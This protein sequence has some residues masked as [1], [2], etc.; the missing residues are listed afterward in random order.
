MPEQFDRLSDYVLRAGKFAD[1]SA[2]REQGMR[3]VRR[4]KAGQIALG[5]GTFALVAGL[6]AVVAASGT[7]NTT[8]G[9]PI[10]GGASA[11]GTPM[12]LIPCAGST[13]RVKGVPWNHSTLTPPAT[14]TTSTSVNSTPTYVPY[15]ANPDDPVGFVRDGRCMQVTFTTPDGI[16]LYGL[17]G[18][19]T[20][21][22]V[23]GLHQVGFTNVT[24]R[25]LPSGTVPA[26]DTID[27]RDS[28]GDSVVGR[29]LIPATTTLVVFY[30]SGT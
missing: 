29:S 14:S 13:A 20:Q 12:P 16:S 18:P 28:R 21:K 3:R 1:P 23:D 11:S 19:T 30:S 25:A 5:T 26:G 7:G 24:T 6:G 4:R 10:G 22:M 27:V 9:T 15:T 2:L 17:L 8:S